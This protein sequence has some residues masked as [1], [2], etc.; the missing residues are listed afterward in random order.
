MKWKEM[1]G[2]KVMKWKLNTPLGSEYDMSSYLRNILGTSDSDAFGGIV[3]ITKFRF[4][5][6]ERE[7]LNCPTFSDSTYLNNLRM[8]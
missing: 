8:Y 4:H 1:K 5:F 2:Y 6:R 3:W 7:P